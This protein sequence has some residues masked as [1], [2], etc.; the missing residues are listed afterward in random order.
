MF[1]GAQNTR[2]P[3]AG[4]DEKNTFYDFYFKANERDATADKPGFS[5]GLTSE[6][7]KTRYSEAHMIEI[8]DRLVNSL[9]YK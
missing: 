7:K 5:I 8:W 2:N 1:G 6:F 4:K 3:A 9:C